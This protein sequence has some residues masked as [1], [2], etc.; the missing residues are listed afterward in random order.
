MARADNSRD[1]CSSGMSRR[2]LRI[3]ESQP[4]VNSIE[5]ESWIPP[6]NKIPDAR[7][8]QDARPETLAGATV[9]DNDAPIRVQRALMLVRG[10]YLRPSWRIGRQMGGFLRQ[11]MERLPNF[12]RE[13]CCHGSPNITRTPAR[14][15]PNTGLY[16]SA[17]RGYVA[18]RGSNRAYDLSPMIS[19]G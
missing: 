10:E 14:K 13:F 12:Q 1:F 4:A 19:S 15:F 8:N 2:N 11:V 9:A 6:S 5:P 17:L 7:V 3:R 18:V 16:A